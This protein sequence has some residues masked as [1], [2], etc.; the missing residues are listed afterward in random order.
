MDTEIIGRTREKELLTGLLESNRPELLALYGRRRVGK[1]FLV[2]EFFEGK[3]RMF[4]ITGAR[5]TTPELQLARFAVEMQ[6]KFQ[7]SGDDA[8]YRN[9]DEALNALVTA[10][11]ST[12]SQASEERL[13]VFFDEIP[14]LDEK[15]S[16]FLS[17][18]DYAWN[19]HF[20]KSRFGKLLIIICGSA[21]SWMIRK[22]INDKGGLHNRVTETLRLM[23]FTLR[24]TRQY[25]ESLDVR[26]DNRQLTEIY[27]ALGG[28]PAYLRHVRPGLSSTQIINELCFTD[29]RFLAEEFDRLYAS[30]FSRHRNHIQIVR[31]LASAPRG[32]TRS[33]VLKKAA[34]ADGGNSSQYL[35][36]LEQSGFISTIP[37]YGR[38]KRGRYYRL[39]DEY[40]LFYLKW[41]E[42]AKP[43]SSGDHDSDYWLRQ[44]QRPTWA[45]WAGYAFEGICLKHV[46]EIKRALGISGVV[47]RAYS[48]ECPPDQERHARGA[49]VD[50]VIERADSTTN[51][52]ELKFVR[53]RFNVSAGYRRELENKRERFRA[54]T[55]TR[56]LLLITLLTT[57]GAPENRNYVG[58][59]DNQLTLDIF[60]T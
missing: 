52:C 47:T 23:P 22:V 27:M 2:D 55:G 39:S 6:N 29:G 34:L 11:E 20:S 32:L 16:G 44:S 46:S 57:Y 38:K 15:N 10:V 36:E 5:N 33:D 24:E 12:L 50:L 26:L 53:D 43:I 56:S 9:W 19:R 41:I 31:A 3:A 25:L 42:S 58:V 17:A 49:Q 60:F 13:V 45:S 30:L 35:T 54:V 21:A 14:W 48:W 40:S 8:V 7:I 28:I 1:T 37:Q 4:A 51:L 18:L 59:V